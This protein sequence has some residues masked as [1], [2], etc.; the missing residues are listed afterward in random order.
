MTSDI[1]ARADVLIAASPEQVWRALTNP[2]AIAEYMF[3][4]KVATDWREGSS[5]TWEGEW[6][7]KRFRDHGKILTVMPGEKLQYTHFSPRSGR[8]DRPQNYHTV[9]ITLIREGDA[10]R[11]QLTQ[12]NNATDEAKS[13]SEENWRQML[14]GL[15]SHVEA[16]TSPATTH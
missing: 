16:R 6:K 2:A 13:H 14:S 8:Q 4:A 3:G 5:I 10:T 7:G 11:V 15:K 12:D 1:I 9:T